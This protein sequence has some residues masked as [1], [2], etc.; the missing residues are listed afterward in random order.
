MKLEEAK[1]QF[2]ETWGTL[3]TNWGINRSMAQIH[4]L[5]M[6][7][8]EPLNTDTIMET[9]QISRGNANMNIRALIDWGLIERRAVRG[10]RV[11]YFS[12]EKDIWKVAIRIL[13]ERRKR[14]LDPLKGYLGN[15]KTIDE[16]DKKAHPAETA[17]FENM[18][19]DLEDFIDTAD[20]ITNKISNVDK[21]WF[22]SSL[23]KF[24]IGK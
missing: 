24:V 7:S 23:M 3:G 17:E 22:F 13:K 21:S 18:V 2:I 11:E 5:L 20:R 4:A 10:E 16:A 19:K 14:E 1:E 15:L 8:T 6:V 12:A 9:L